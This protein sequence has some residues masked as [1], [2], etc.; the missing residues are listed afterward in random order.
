MRVAELGDAVSALGQRYTKVELGQATVQGRTLRLPDQEFILDDGGMQ[1]LAKRLRTPVS[2]L[3]RLPETMSD[4]ILNYFIQQHEDAEVVLAH[5]ADV[6]TAVYDGKIDTVRFDQYAEVVA[7]VMD[8]DAMVSSFYLH[9]GAMRV[10]VLLEESQVEARVG[11]VTRAGA[12]FYGHIAP[13]VAQPY[14]HTF[15]NRLICDNGMVVEESDGLVAIRG[16]TVED[17]LAEMELAAMRVLS[18]NDH[19]LGQW[20]GLVDVEVDN[21]EQMI[22]R[23]ATEHGISAAVESRILDRVPEMEGSTLYDVI[24]LMTSMHQEEGITQGQVDRLQLMAGGTIVHGATHR[25]PSCQHRL[26]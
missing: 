23:L 18:G 24:N 11:D 5:E 22:H 3:E 14:V 10:D 4:D 15:L 20:A 1:A 6:L 9:D 7:S 25:C 2:F 12:R 21:A 17:I 26:G 16:N 8:P 13:A 19:R